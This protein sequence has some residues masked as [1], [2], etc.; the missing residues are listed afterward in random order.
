MGISLLCLRTR[1]N[2]SVTQSLGR[3]LCLGQLQRHKPAGWRS[4]PP[5]PT[6]GG[7]SR[8]SAPPVPLLRDTSLPGSGLALQLE[9][10]GSPPYT[11]LMHPPTTVPAL[12]PKRVGVVCPPGAL[13]PS[14]PSRHPGDPHPGSGHVPRGI[15]AISSVHLGTGG[16]GVFPPFYM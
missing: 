1:L 10:R 6:P 2:T 13:A 7:L 3:V 12:L 15:H 8:C 16:T 11:P 4:Q 9:T 5:A 14:H